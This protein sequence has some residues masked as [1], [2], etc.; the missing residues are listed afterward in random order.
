[1]WWLSFIWLSANATAAQEK[2]PSVSLLPADL[3]SL[4]NLCL[5]LKIACRT[6]ITCTKAWSGICHRPHNH[7]LLQALS[8]LSEHSHYPH[9]AYLYS[10][11]WGLLLKRVVMVDTACSSFPTAQPRM[12][13]GFSKLIEKYCYIIFRERLFSDVPLVKNWCIHQG[14]VI[15]SLNFLVMETQES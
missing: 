5:S 14:W 2:Q 8:L 9:F 15:S 4:S 12:Q 3:L 13:E 7:Q 10:Y 11:E 1:M 6:T